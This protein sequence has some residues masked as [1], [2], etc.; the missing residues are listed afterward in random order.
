[1]KKIHLFCFL[2][3]TA[4]SVIA[5]DQQLLKAADYG[6]KWPFTVK[7]GFVACPDGQSVIF[8]TGAK[9]YALNGVAKSKGYTP[10]EPIWR[11]DPEMIKMQ[12]EIAKSEKKSL[13]EIQNNM[14]PTP[15]VSIGPVLDKGLKLCR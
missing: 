13:K 1:M 5:A 11:L 4:T 10:I 8:L 14:G 2:V 9:K 3:L 6:D 12:K 15:R 7:E